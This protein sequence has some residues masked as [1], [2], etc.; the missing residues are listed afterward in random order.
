VG[1]R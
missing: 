1:L